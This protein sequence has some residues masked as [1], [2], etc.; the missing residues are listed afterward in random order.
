MDD[1]NE[2]DPHSTVK[3]E[4]DSPRCNCRR[5]GNQNIWN[6]AGLSKGFWITSQRRYG[7]SE[8]IDG[9]VHAALDEK[10]HERLYSKDCLLIGRTLERRG[11][12]DFVTS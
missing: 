1:P 6:G 10:V 4:R 7:S 5:A 12:R 11:Y 3:R 9:K 8:T 2:K